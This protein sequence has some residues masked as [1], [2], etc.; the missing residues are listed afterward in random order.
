MQKS[1]HP[2]IISRFIGERVIV[3]T[4]DETELSGDLVHIDKSTHRGW[5]GNVIMR[6]D[7]GLSIIRGEY[8]QIIASGD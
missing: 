2:R 4:R 7:G 3:K 6:V 5:F 1:L 8:V